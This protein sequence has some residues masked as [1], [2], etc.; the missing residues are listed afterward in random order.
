M[1]SYESFSQI[2]ENMFRGLDLYP[3][4]RYRMI[5]KVHSLKNYQVMKLKEDAKHMGVHLSDYM[6]AV[7]TKKIPNTK[8]ARKVHKDNIIKPYPEDSGYIRILE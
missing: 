1:R 7:L 8:I 3:H 5:D 4:I 6:V 2:L